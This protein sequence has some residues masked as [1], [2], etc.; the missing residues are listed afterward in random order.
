MAE[1]R[2]RVYIVGGGPG[3]PELITVKGLKLV[4]EADVILYDRL[5]PRGVLK[6]AKPGAVLVDVGKKPGGGGP[7]QEEINKMLVDY[8][9]RGMLV[10]RLKGGDPYVFGRGEEE[11]LFVKSHGIDCEVVPGVPSF[12]AAAARSGVPLTSRGLSSS[13]AVVTGQEDPGK[14]FKAVDLAK[15]ASAVDVIVI[16]MGVSRAREILEEIASVRGYQELAAV[17]IRATM[18][19][20]KVIAGTIEDLIE[21]SER[22]ELENPA[23][24]IVGRTVALRE[25]LA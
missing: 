14:G 25:K 23:V 18:E 15:V 24:I 20:E 9:M 7:S 19:S 21:A 22:G 2:G 10:V 12:I 1:R 6:E 11:C 4:R 8:A 16:L 3:D 5:A 17:V 13:F